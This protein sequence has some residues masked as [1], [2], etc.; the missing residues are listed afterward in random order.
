MLDKIKK[1]FYVTLGIISLG[2]I[3]KIIL[4]FFIKKELIKDETKTTIV[5]TKNKVTNVVKYKQKLNQSEIDKIKHSSF[6]EL[7]K[8]LRE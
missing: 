3:I 6:I 8:Q 1:Y 5:K 2:F 4:G 7:V